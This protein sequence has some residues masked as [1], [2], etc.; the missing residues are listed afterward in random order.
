MLI[1]SCVLDKGYSKENICLY[2]SK[3]GACNYTVGISLIAFFVGLGFLICTY[4][5]EQIS[6][7]VTRFDS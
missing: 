7:T 1:F 4:F 6:N 5:W 3:Q 2:N